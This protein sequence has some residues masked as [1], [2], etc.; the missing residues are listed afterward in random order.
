MVNYDALLDQSDAR[1]LRCSSCGL[2]DCDCNL[3][4]ELT[5]EVKDHSVDFTIWPE[6]IDGEEQGE[7]VT[8]TMGANKSVRVLS[9]ALDQIRAKNDRAAQEFGTDARRATDGHAP[10]GAGAMRIIC[11]AAASLSSEVFNAV[12]ARA[13]GL[14]P[15]EARKI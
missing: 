10:P 4:A 13:A 2:E 9:R 15:K 3:P 6:R 14:P 7:P 5:I 8:C 11:Q 1:R 12:C